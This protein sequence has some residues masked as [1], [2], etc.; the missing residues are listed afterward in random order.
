M[1]GIWKVMFLFTSVQ[2]N[3]VKIV[4]DVNIDEYLILYEMFSVQIWL[5]SSVSVSVRIIQRVVYWCWNKL[6]Y[7]GHYTTES[8]QVQT[9]IISFYVQSYI[10]ATIKK[11][12]LKTKFE[13]N[14]ITFYHLI[15]NQ[16]PKPTVMVCCI[17]I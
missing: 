9:N 13:T 11:I 7:S 3:D 14:W 8:E 2:F 5:K 6:R 10:F 12:H 15:W 1:V 16:F 17:Y 4:V